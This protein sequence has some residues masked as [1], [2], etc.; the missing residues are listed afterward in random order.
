MHQYIVLYFDISWAHIQDTSDKFQFDPFLLSSSRYLANIQNGSPRDPLTK[1]MSNNK[2]FS[3][4]SLNV[5]NILL[6]GFTFYVECRIDSR[7]DL[8][9]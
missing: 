4:F 2:T 9:S 7:I 5:I 6:G 3:D 1:R 8:T